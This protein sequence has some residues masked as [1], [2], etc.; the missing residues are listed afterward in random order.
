MVPNNIPL[1]LGLSTN[2]I[3]GQVPEHLREDDKYGLLAALAPGSKFSSVIFRTVDTKGLDERLGLSLRAINTIGSVLTDCEPV[4]ILVEPLFPPWGPNRHKHRDISKFGA[5][6]EGAIA[7][8]RGNAERLADQSGQEVCYGLDLEP[9]S[10]S[11]YHPD[12]YLPYQ[13]DDEKKHTNALLDYYRADVKA[14][15]D[16][17]GPVDWV[18]PMGWTRSST[19]AKLYTALRGLGQSTMSW[20][21]YHDPRHPQ[22]LVPALEK[23][24]PGTLPA[25][26]WSLGIYLHKNF[27]P[28]TIFKDID[29]AAWARWYNEDLGV[30]FPISSAT[31]WVDKGHLHWLS[32]LVDTLPNKSRNWLQELSQPSPIP[33]PASEFG[34]RNGQVTPGQ[35]DS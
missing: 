11:A 15:V 2:Y 29:W 13:T 9:V 25:T 23:T 21:T 27:S 19:V 20:Q 16:W 32:K 33:T 35:F 5:L 34:I 22:A 12:R 14:A 7:R 31:F 3:N 17:I 18:A 6:V 24:P 10:G 1:Q 26:L 28:P 30:N 4:P 8:V